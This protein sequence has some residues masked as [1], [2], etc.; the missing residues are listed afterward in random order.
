MLYYSVPP[1]E[2]PALVASPFLEQDATSGFAQ[3][4]VE[5]K[6]LPTITQAKTLPP[7]YTPSHPAQ[8][9]ELLE[10]QIPQPPLKK[11]IWHEKS[12]LVP[13]KA[14]V[15]SPNATPTPAPT[16]TPS[17][18][19]NEEEFI[20]FPVGINVGKRNVISSILVRGKED[21]SQAI[22]FNNWLLP[23]DS[24]LQALK[25]STNI[26]P[27]GQVELRSPGLVTRIDLKKL[28]T[29]PELGTVFSVQELQTLFGVSAEFDINEYAIR[30]QV[31]WADLKNQTAEETEIPVQLEGLP[32]I[33]APSANLTAIQQR[34]NISGSQ[35]TSQSYRG[36]LTA[37]GN[38]LDGSWFIRAEQ[39]SLQDWQTWRIAEAQFLRQT[40]RTDYFI[41]SQSPFW[42]N[43]GDGGYW[44]FTLIQRNGFTPP[45][46][47]SG[48]ADPRQRLRPDQFGRTISGRAEPGTLVRLTQGF[49]DRAIAEVLV[50]SSGIYRFENIKS[51]SSNY[52]ILLYPEGR[53]TAQTEIRDA[54]FSIVSGQIPAGTSALII[55]GGL[56]RESSGEGN[57]IGNFSDFRGGIAQRWGLSENLTVGLGAIHDQSFMGF[58]ELFFQPKNLPLKVAVSALT[59]A[60]GSSWDINTDI[61]FEPSS[62]LR[63]TFNSD[64]LSSRF[65]VN[66]QVLPSL[67]LFSTA[68]SRDAPSVGLQFSKSSRNSYTS[69]RASLDT[70][71]RLRWNLTQRLGNLEF[72]QRGNEIGTLSELG[73]NFSSK[74]SFSSSSSLLLRYETR[75]QNNRSDNN[76]ATLTWRY[77]SPKRAIDGSSLWEAQL[78]YGI[79]SQ[80]TG[81]IAT[82]GTTVIPGLLLRGRYQGVSVTSD[83]A[84]F[85]I[86]LVSSLDLQ[87]G[88]SIG[89][90]RSDDFR[91]QGGLLIQ[92]FFDR[93]GN[94]KW[95]AAEKIYTDNSELLL[96]LNNKPIK[97][98]R[99]EVRGDRILVHLTPGKYRLDLDPAGFPPDWQAQVNA[100]AVDV[101]AGSYTPIL[102]PLALSYTRSGIITDAQGKPI[103]GAR[104]EAVSTSGGKGAFSITNAAGVY[105][106][107]QM[108]QGTYNLQI[109]GKPGQPSTITLDQSS[110]PFQEL[111]L[112][113]P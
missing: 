53:L 74:N 100:Y 2:P 18:E 81:L 40:D 51:A 50:D 86:E 44:G 76:I 83:Q 78:G 106:L 39:P 11:E 66:W 23:Y 25:F 52:R 70:R 99:P 5:Q 111:N 37:V 68:D 91:T 98:F 67:S 90:R 27:D 112:Q 107:E 47:I 46:Q 48:G 42:R 63:A 8:S 4:V 69:V 109:N 38:F 73:Y 104:V 7:D 93:N 62:N 75:N 41:G 10:R 88:I 31:P 65:N 84:T 92:P 45:P 54:S 64:H 15:S 102:V 28:R 96:I 85:N 95:D 79:S 30:L 32:R 43:Q 13:V 35:T 34:V 24:V 89:D 1:P 110:E 58:G 71:D 17:A 33:N 60:A 6:S 101:V 22:D 82:L 29:D 94:G 12:E 21:G 56:R 59:G 49:S 97:F 16:A 105:Y 57:L 108:Q 14:E 55:S 77:R 26:L 3:T 80:G 36:E 61:S 103:N 19:I 9:A 87:R 72:T 113:Q 20:V